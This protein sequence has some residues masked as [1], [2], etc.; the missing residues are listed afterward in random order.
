MIAT[1]GPVKNIVL[2]PINEGALFSQRQT[3]VFQFSASNVNQL[4]ID[5]SYLTFN[6][7]V[8]VI[9][10]TAAA[11]RTNMYALRD[12]AM[13]FS[14]VRV[15]YEGEIIY[16]QQNNI[17]AQLLKM[18]QFG[19]NYLEQ[20]PANYVTTKTI[21]NGAAIG[22]LPS[23]PANVNANA[24]YTH[25]KIGLQ[26]RLKELLPIF[27]SFQ[28][29]N[30]S[31]PVN[32]LRSQITIEL[33][34]AQPQR[35]F[36]LLVDSAYSYPRTPLTTDGLSDPGEICYA[37]ALS[38]I[39]NVQIKDPRLYLQFYEPSDDELK[40]L[41]S[42]HKGGNFVWHYFMPSIA[43]RNL[44][45]PSATFDTGAT[46]MFNIP[47]SIV[48]KNVD[49]FLIWGSEQNSP[50]TTIRLAARN[51]NVKFGINQV[52]FTPISDNSCTNPGQ[53]R[54]QVFNVYD[55]IGTYYTVVNDELVA[56]YYVPNA[57][58]D[59]GDLNFLIGG[60]YTV[61]DEL[62]ANSDSWNS[63]YTLQSMLARPYTGAQAPANP[64]EVQLTMAVFSRYTLYL[65]DGKL[66]TVNE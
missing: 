55:I 58:Y 5:N 22:F 54:D 3:I 16:Q 25:N 64:P 30:Q 49:K 14:D 59:K 2:P 65:R 63:Q 53:Y 19:T 29:E 50:C 12:S 7:D 66:F 52:P 34:I 15:K 62:G 28:D 57:D 51:C 46:Q 11:A 9:N 24:T 38:N 10:N 17:Q 8:D 35:A 31:F 39:S 42:R 47:F 13:I 48:T 43:M 37:A 27:E 32:F 56:S 40:T 36:A 45:I 21:K 1:I 61:S 23:S 44:G 33:D 60:N 6:M 26:V 18:T 41:N 4:L 20:N